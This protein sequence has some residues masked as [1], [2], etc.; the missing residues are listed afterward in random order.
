[1]VMKKIQI[2]NHKGYGESGQEDKVAKMFTWKRRTD[3]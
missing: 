1:M 2:S 3:I